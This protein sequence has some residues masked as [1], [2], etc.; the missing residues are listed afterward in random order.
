MSIIGQRELYSYKYTM[1]AFLALLCLAAL[2]Y[3]APADDNSLWKQFKQTHSKFYE[4]ENEEQV[5]K[6]IF[7][8]NK[9]K[10]DAHNL[11]HQNGEVTFTMKMNQF[12]DLLSTEF[13]TF[14]NGFNKTK[15]QHSAQPLYKFTRNTNVEVSKSVDWRKKGAV[16]PVK[17]QKQCGSCWAFSSTGSLEGQHFLKTGKLV[18]LSEQ[19]LVDC[20]GS[21][22]NLGC[23][24]GLMDLA[25]QYVRDNKGLDT[26]KSYPYW[27]EDESCRFKPS[28]VGATDKGYVDV[29]SNDEHALE[30]AVDKVGPVSV[31]MDASHESFQFYSSGIYYE[32]DCDSQNLDHGVLVVGYGT[33]GKN[34]FWL[35]KNSWNTVWGEKGYFK[36]AKNKNNHCGVATSASYPVV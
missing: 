7:L 6:A 9:A 29:A 17:D 18:S 14:Y 25:F 11:R 15:S 4:T 23:S 31:A 35:V 21:Y 2:A 33:Q 32:P 12:G 36:L 34:E 16:T 20:S 10:I 5:R 3:S 27:G 26:E 1:K 24:G 19:N 8:Q 22:G 28:G 13:R 30:E